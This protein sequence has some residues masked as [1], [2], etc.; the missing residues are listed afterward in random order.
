M[1]GDIITIPTLFDLGKSGIQNA[2]CT[3][4]T[5]FSFAGSRP[6]DCIANKNCL[7]DVSPLGGLAKCRC[8]VSNADDL[9]SVF[10]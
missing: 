9:P 8:D 5:P 3:I 10:C 7:S 4:T 6:A 2:G 1:I